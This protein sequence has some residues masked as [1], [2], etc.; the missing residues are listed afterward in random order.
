MAGTQG[1]LSEIAELFEAAARPFLGKERD[2]LLWE[3]LDMETRLK[4][5]RWVSS[6]GLR[7]PRED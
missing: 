5:E 6:I 2:D 3:A 1:F 4:A 7:P